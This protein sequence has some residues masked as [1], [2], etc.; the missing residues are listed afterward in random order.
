MFIGVV[1]LLR[2]LI[3]RCVLGHK[4]PSSLREQRALGHASQFATVLA[5]QPHA[6]QPEQLPPCSL[7]HGRSPPAQPLQG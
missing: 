3:G 1:R 2:A 4:K 7:R 6:P 5:Q